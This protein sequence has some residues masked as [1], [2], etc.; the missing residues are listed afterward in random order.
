LLFEACCGPL[1]DARCGRD[2]PFDGPLRPGPRGARST[3]RSNG[4]EKALYGPLNVG[5]GSRVPF[6]GFARRAVVSLKWRFWIRANVPGPWM[7]RSLGPSFARPNRWGSC[8]GLSAGPHLRSGESPQSPRRV[9]TTRA[10]HAAQRAFRFSIF[11]FRFSIFDFQE[12]HSNAVA[13]FPN[14]IEAPSYQTPYDAPNRIRPSKKTKKPKKISWK[15]AA[16]QTLISKL[17]SRSGLHFRRQRTSPC[18]TG[19]SRPRW[20][21]H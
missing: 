1:I 9:I 14:G 13:Q 21:G 11:D 15:T 12:C 18:R 7:G 2:G 5:L 20:A 3:V 19:P 4:P 17:L 10:G 6:G 8:C 16:L